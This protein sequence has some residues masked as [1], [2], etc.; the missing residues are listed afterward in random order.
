MIFHYPWCIID[1]LGINVVLLKCRLGLG[2]LPG[3]ICG[4]EEH[5][6]FYFFI[7]TSVLISLLFLYYWDFLGDDLPPQPIQKAILA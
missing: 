5:Y 3:D 7:T 4:G 1:Y 2:N 6:R